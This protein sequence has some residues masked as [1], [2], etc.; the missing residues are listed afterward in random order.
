GPLSIEWEDVRM[1]RVHG[2][3]ESAAFCR[4]L[5]FTPSAAAFDAAFSEDRG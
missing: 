3:T 4:Q 5:D 1:D 2:A